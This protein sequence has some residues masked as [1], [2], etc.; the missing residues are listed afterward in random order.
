MVENSGQRRVQ[1]NSTKDTTTTELEQPQQ[2]QLDSHDGG[3][4]FA[5]G[6]DDDYTVEKST[7]RR[8]K[9]CRSY[10]HG[11]DHFSP[12][13]YPSHGSRSF[14]TSQWMSMMACFLGLV[15]WIW[16]L[17]EASFCYHSMSYLPVT[18]LY[19]LTST[20]QFCIV[21]IMYNGN[22][23][24]CQLDDNLTC[25]SGPGMMASILAAILY[26]V[27]AIL[28]CTSPIARPIRHGSPAS[29]ESSTEVN[30]QRKKLKD[31][32]RGT[33]SGRS[34]V[35]GGRLANPPANYN[36]DYDDD[37]FDDE[38]A[39]SSPHHFTIDDDDDDLLAE[40]TTPREE[41]N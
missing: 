8:K 2:P 40:T 5:L 26:L 27:C 25:E 33:A 38:G 15:S 4:D 11:I 39:S 7:Y 17:S 21:P 34:I 16:T 23:S 29:E 19:V 6:G 24:I 18:V 37:Y 10:E 32:D 9:V 13:M 12:Q 36:D 31:A 20:L 14:H 41:W 3:D 1:K 30:D 28:E 22:G 35:G